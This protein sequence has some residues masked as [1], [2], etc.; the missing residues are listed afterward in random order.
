[1]GGY[2][3]VLNLHGGMVHIWSVC[4]DSAR[5]MENC[6][7]RPKITVDY[8]TSYYGRGGMKIRL[9]ILKF[10]MTFQCML[11]KRSHFTNT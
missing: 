4:T 1:M 2:V 7:F 9:F 3:F 11:E 10:F 8:T 6:D 5:L